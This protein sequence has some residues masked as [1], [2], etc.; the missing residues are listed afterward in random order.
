MP[1]TEILNVL[2]RSIYKQNN[3]VS[4]IFDQIN[5]VCCKKNSLFVKV[6]QAANYIEPQSV[7]NPLYLNEVSSV[8]NSFYAQ[9]FN[10]LTHIPMEVYSSSSERWIQNIKDSTGNIIINQ[11]DIMSY[12]QND[13]KQAHLLGF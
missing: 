8:F 13:F 7:F 11:S 3:Y 1:Q 12:V 4:L 5:D 10:G 9:E 6:Y 2:Y